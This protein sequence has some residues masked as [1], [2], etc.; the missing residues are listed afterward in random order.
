MKIF[1]CSLLDVVRFGVNVWV[2]DS[3]LGEFVSSVRWDQGLLFLLLF[4]FPFLFGN[5]YPLS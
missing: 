4:F 5:G 2:G 1:S 3:F